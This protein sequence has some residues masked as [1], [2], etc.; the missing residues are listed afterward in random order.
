MPLSKQ[1]GKGVNED[2]T[3]NGNFDAS[4][5]SNTAQGVTSGDFIGEGWS[6]PPPRNNS[7]FRPHYPSQNPFFYRKES[8]IKLPEFDWS[9]YT[10]VRLEYPLPRSDGKLVTRN[11]IYTR[12]P[13]VRRKKQAF[14]F[15]F[16]RENEAYDQFE[17]CIIFQT[18]TIDSPAFSIHEGRA[19]WIEFRMQK[20]GANEDTL[21]FPIAE[22]T[23]E[24]WHE[25]TVFVTYG[26][27]SDGRVTVWYGNKLARFHNRSG[28]APNHTYAKALVNQNSSSAYGTNSQLGTTPMS[29][30]DDGIPVT[31]FDWHGFTLMNNQSI[32]SISQK[33]GFYKSTDFCRSTTEALA[34]F[35]SGNFEGATL[36]ETAAN[37]VLKDTSIPDE[38]Q[39]SFTMYSHMNFAYWG[40]GESDEDIWKLL[41]NGESP[42][43][44][45]DD[46]SWN[47]L[48]TSTTTTQAPTTTTTQAPTT[49]TTQSPT[50]TTKAP[51][52]QP[53][54]PKRGKNKI[55]SNFIFSTGK[56][57]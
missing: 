54:P 30:V 9:M 15:S 17:R 26:G 20:S 14:K 47:T 3:H 19:G 38:D 23:R 53:N 7:G 37:C 6:I 51:N 45:P 22:F 55:R 57:N 56:Q 50:T 32:S 34:R 46:F 16:Y 44:A 18:H 43:E 1:Y 25:V 11:E 31:L 41:N 39:R 35:E 28:S 21:F 52:K 5:L 12:H 36:L 24:V 29:T 4:I 33:W 49:T 27:L 42:L 10:H 48:G 40:T 8:T 13:D 2:V